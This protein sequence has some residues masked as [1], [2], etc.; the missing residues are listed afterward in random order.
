MTNEASAE[1]GV[2][3]L[4]DALLLYDKSTITGSQLGDLIGK[5]FPELNVRKMTQIDSGPGALTK[6]VEMRLSDILHI[7][8]KAG[9]DLIFSIKKT[10]E[11]TD[12][13]NEKSDTRALRRFVLHAV[14]RMAP[15]D[16]RRI[17]IP[18]EL[19]YETAKNSLTE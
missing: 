1:A 17:L 3:N 12:S 14:S 13:T 5:R 7:A 19:A 8:G 2:R 6:F 15:D 9:A 18:A 11:Q 16:L 4:S 10:V